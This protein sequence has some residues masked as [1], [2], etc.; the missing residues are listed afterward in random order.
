[1]NPVDFVFEP[2]E[3]RHTLLKRAVLPRYQMWYSVT[4][5]HHKHADKLYAALA[6]SIAPSA[7]AR[8]RPLASASSSETLPM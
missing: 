5:V 6:S 4:T 3:K 1:M 7:S 8:V 2:R